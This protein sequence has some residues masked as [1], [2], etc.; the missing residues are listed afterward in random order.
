MMAAVVCGAVVFPGLFYSF[1]KI[2]KHTWTEWS[3][4]DVVSVSER[5]VSA[6]HASLACAAGVTVVSSCQDV[7][8]DSHWM[9]N[10]FVLFGAPYMIFDIYAMYLTHFHTERTRGGAKAPVEH[11]PQTVKAFLRKNWM[12]VLHHMALILIFMPI[13]LVRSVRKQ[14]Q[15]FS[16]TSAVVSQCTSWRKTTERGSNSRKCSIGSS[17]FQERAGGFLHWL[18]VHHRAQHSFHLHWKDPHSAAP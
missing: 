5:L 15:P 10:N 18:P 3:D 2:L 14:S 9:V 11:S 13:T 4:A 1:R 6:V 16:R 7:M 12:L 17:V 8:T